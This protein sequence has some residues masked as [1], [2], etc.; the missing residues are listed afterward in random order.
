VI[1]PHRGF[2]IDFVPWAV[3]RSGSIRYPQSTFTMQS[4]DFQVVLDCPIEMVFAIYTDV[5]RWC[6][7]NLFGEI[8]WVQGEPWKEGS[9]LRIET[10][11]PIRTSIDQVVQHFTPNESVSYL[12][13]VLGITCETRVFFTRV[14]EGKTAINVGMHLVG[15]VS[16][17]LGF[18]IEPVI[19]KSTKGFFEELRKECEMESRKARGMEPNT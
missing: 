13:H 2:L 19:A 17:T 18:A 6:N 7:R 14:A 3:G 5:E 16:R 9:R 8:R 15:T 1:C 4:F 12:S 11:S 10:R